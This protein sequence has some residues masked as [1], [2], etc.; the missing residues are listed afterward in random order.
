MRKKCQ[1]LLALILTAAVLLGAA[2]NPGEEGERE[3]TGAQTLDLNKNLSREE[4]KSLLPQN[5]YTD[6][7]NMAYW[8]KLLAGVKHSGNWREDLVH[9]AM[10]QIGYTES[11]LNVRRD[12]EGESHGYTRY[13]G[14]YGVPH[15]EWCAMFISFCLYFARIPEEAVPHEASCVRWEDALIRQ[16]LFNDKRD[17]V[18]QRGDLIF[19]GSRGVPWHVGIV[20]ELDEETGE[21]RYIHGNTENHD[22]AY[23]SIPRNS[24]V[25]VGYGV[26]PDNPD[27]GVTVSGS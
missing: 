5:S 2:P 17:Y 1:R 10:T 25:I 23:G 14:W 20:T 15:A 11:R 7:E 24:G 13:G 26:L 6:V 21:V 8:Q 27:A 19:L 3:E 9:I 12:D 16:G 22:V 4:D 18:P